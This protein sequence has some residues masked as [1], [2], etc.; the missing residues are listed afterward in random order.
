[1]DFKIND[2]V[3][4]RVKGH[5]YWPARVIKVDTE[6]YKSVVKYELNFFATNE[7]ATVNKTD[8]CHYSQNKSKYSL[9]SVAL[10]H[11][12]IYCRALTEIKKAS[13]NK[14]S[15]NK[16]KSPKMQT[17]LTPMKLIRTSTPK[18]PILNEKNI[19]TTP[20]HCLHTE[21]HKKDVSVNTTLDLDLLYQR[22]ALTDKCI[23]L[24]RTLIE[25]NDIIRN[26]KRDNAKSNQG[27]YEDFH[28][29]ILKT[30]LN[31]YKEEN[32]NLQ[33]TITL[34][35]DD[36]QKLQKELDKINI[37][38]NCL[39]CYPPLQTSPLGNSWNIVRTPNRSHISPSSVNISC[40][41]RFDALSNITA[42]EDMEL[43]RPILNKNK[44]SQIYFKQGTKSTCVEK[45]NN[46]KNKLVILADS[47]G[48]SLSN[49]IE[50][51]T[52]FDVC[53]YV[54]SGAKFDQ[55]T[56]EVRELS[57]D[58][59]ANDY[60]LVVAGTN[61]I[62]T[63]GIKRLTNDVHKLIMNT[64]HTNLILATVPMRH[65][66]PNL[67]FKIS[68]VN[69]EIEKIVMEYT[70]VKLLPLHLLPRHMFTSHGLH[71][72]NKGKVN[73][74]TTISNML[75]KTTK[76][77]LLT[78]KFNR[79]EYKDNINIVDADMN[80]I[81]AQMKNDPTV[82]FAHT[83]SA[84][85][86][87]P[88]H[89]SAGVAVV[90]RRSFGRPLQDDYIDKRLTCQ[91]VMNGAHIYGLVT[92][93]IFKGKPALEDYNCAFTQLTGD[94]RKK[95]LKTLVCHPM[96]TVRDLIQPKHFL[97]NIIEFQHSTKA[98]VYIVCYNE[99]SSRV[100]RDGLPH[101]VFLKTLKELIET[102]HNEKPVNPLEPNSGATVPPSPQS[103]N[104]GQ[105]LEDIVCSEKSL[106]GESVSE[107]AMYVADK[108]SVCNCVV[109]VEDLNM[110]LSPNIN[111]QC[112]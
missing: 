52:N 29:Q 45:S 25:K 94:F 61:N 7:V 30:E 105:L 91:R 8:L 86:N 84:D 92:K 58:L 97:K 39:T 5:P 100:L 48:K 87:N 54:R 2:L 47:H 89:M 40:K 16:T 50:R 71:F 56:E 23:S 14:K 19:S 60:L 26:L 55:V 77:T 53:S 109:Q 51:K 111:K 80:D 10:K 66:T 70:N 96:G 3:F 75:L 95:G 38:N 88:R 15:F 93:P 76:E 82:G 57:R 85:F 17:K 62:E 43:K 11:R 46:H 81:I 27:Q 4:G 20:E 41:N 83:I 49:L 67:D 1:M 73:I 18:T 44:T 98:T 32:K 28:T 37:Y 108:S 22:D 34:L 104:S 36:N 13:E 102:N 68:I 107:G 103:T 63:T 59:S 72:N 79:S 69:T 65:D 6:T 110:S 31:R 90:F 42:L 12:E 64:K 112:I 106:S 21:L 33:Q 35:Q 9:E 99:K 78:P 101:S 74:T 24:E